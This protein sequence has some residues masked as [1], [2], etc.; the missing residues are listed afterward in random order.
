[1]SGPAKNPLKITDLTFRDGHQSLFA[2]RMRT[3]DI[4]AIAE[5]AGKV[6]YH[7]M[8][9]WGGATFDTMHRFLG[10]DPWDRPKR[11]RQY[12]PKEVKFQMLLRGQNLVGYRNY[13]DDMANAFVDQAC[14]A[15]VDIYRI[16]DALNDERNFQTVAKRVLENGKHFQA[17]LSY[18]VTGR[19]MGGDIFNLKYWTAKA[20]TFA[21]MGAH[22]ICIK[23][24]AGLL[25]PDD[26]ALLIPAIK[27]ATKLPV[28]LHCHTT[29]GMAEYTFL[30][31]IDA[32]VDIID[33]CSAPFAGRSSHPAL[34]PIVVMLQGTDRDTGFDLEV[35]A[36]ITEYLE[37]I[38]P[39]YRQLLDTSRLAVADI[40]VLM[41]QTPGGMLSNLVNQLREA[42]AMDRLNDVFKELPKVREDLGF[43]PLVTPSSQIVGVQAVMNVLMGKVGGSVKERYKMVSGQV[44]DYCYGLYGTP[45]RPMNPEV[46]KLALKGYPRGETPITCRPADVLEPE[47]EKARAEI[48]DLAKTDADLILYNMFP[49]TGKKFLSVKY[50]KEPA[51]A[52]WAPR[53]MEQAAAESELCRK[54][55]AG[56]LI[57]RPVK[58]APAKGPGLR[59]FNVF[60][61]GEYFEVD[62]ESVGGAPV[63][64]AV[65]APAVAAA[66]QA[67]PVA[68]PAPAAPAPAAPQAAT[69][70]A[71]AP[72]A[73][74]KAAAAAGKGTI[75]AP[76]PGMV[77]DYLVKPGDTVQA[78]DV[79]V[80]LE[81]M[82]MENSLEAPV[83]GVV[84]PLPYSAGDSVA[85][86][87]VLLTI[88]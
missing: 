81:A 41:H 43:P 20:K 87:D 74:P 10:E 47:L 22:S 26:A 55:L 6:G 45:P 70:P 13:A 38:A 60:V 50:G 11:L 73:A 46:Q 62:V 7:A 54:A 31:A 49:T 44:K 59:T 66:P 80:I 19:R 83:D 69:A 35:L 34:E 27:K 15:G 40:G 1:M 58:E 5:T 12:V 76:M 23:D 56:E 63:V 21:S 85:K 39:K 82:K 53:T 25:S 52:E 68:A 71:P 37:T 8:E 3:E 51:P 67:A 2:T 88:D 57:D 79:V 28:E 9:V 14:E 17:A 75:Q 84:G 36:E 42:G 18:T 78:G 33:T 30:K 65:A 86:G 61:D 16:F 4:E 48:G 77:V 72:V 29:S 64:T 24:M 32:G